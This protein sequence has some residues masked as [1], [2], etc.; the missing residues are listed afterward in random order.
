MQRES[1]YQKWDGWFKHSI[2]L[3]LKPLQ[4][5]YLAYFKSQYIVCWRVSDCYRFAALA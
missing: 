2:V 3:T 1:E 5:A 4:P